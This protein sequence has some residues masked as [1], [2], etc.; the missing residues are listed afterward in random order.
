MRV[1]G[2]AQLLAF[3]LVSKQTHHGG[4]VLITLGMINDVAR[5]VVV[6]SRYPSARKIL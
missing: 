2:Y 6:G 1:R 5:S 3:R 4:L